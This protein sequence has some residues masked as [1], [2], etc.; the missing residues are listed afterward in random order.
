MQAAFRTCLNRLLVQSETII[1]RLERGMEMCT[2]QSELEGCNTALSSLYIILH[3]NGA[4]HSLDE[5][6]LQGSRDLL[7]GQQGPFDD[8]SQL[9]GRWE[10]FWQ[11]L[12][13]N[14]S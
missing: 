7:R 14:T 6:R 12:P 3:E 1:D 9:L 4:N 8:A 10:A 2:I 5:L 13:Y 11:F